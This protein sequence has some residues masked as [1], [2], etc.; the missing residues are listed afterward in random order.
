[1]N[2]PEP[3]T[4]QS[5]RIPVVTT[6]TIIVLVVG[7]FASACFYIL[8]EHYEQERIRRDLAR[9]IDIR[10]ALLRGNLQS[11]QDS[12]H[13]L[14]LLFENSEDI[15]WDE[16]Q[17]A[18]KDILSRYDSI[19]AIQWI[20]VVSR[21][22]RV[23]VETYA[24]QNIL[25]DYSFKDRLPD[26][27]T[28]SPSAD[29]DVYLPIL[30]NFPLEPNKAASGYNLLT[31]PTALAIERAR[32]TGKLSLTPKFNLIQL[33]S[34]VVM[35]APIQGKPSVRGDSTYGFVQIV[36]R[37]HDMLDNLWNTT[38]T[39]ILDFM[40]LDT[41]VPKTIPDV[42]FGRLANGMPI[43][44]ETD[45]ASFTNELTTTNSLVIG[46]RVWTAYY[47][48]SAG[49]L[50]QQDSGL[51][52]LTLAGCL[53]LAALGT[54]YVRT[55]GQR[56][57]HIATEV[58]QRTSELRHTKQLLETDIQQRRRTEAELQ[59]TS[60]QLS[61]ILGQIPGMVYRCSGSGTGRLLFVSNRSREITAYN[62][63]EIMR[64]GFDYLDLVHAD[65][66]DR[67]REVIRQAVSDHLPFEI[68]YRLHDRHGD[69]KWV[70]DRG[71]G[72]FDT[73][74]KLLFIEGLAIN[75]DDRRNAESEKLL[76]ERKLLEGQKLESLG[77]LAG[78]IAHDFNNLLTG[79]LG[80]ANLIKQSEI[81]ETCIPLVDR[82]ERSAL[83]AAELC[84]QMLA[85]SGRGRFS[86]QTIHL[87]QIAGDLLPLIE[88]SIS[89]QAR[90]HFDFETPSIPV[91][92]DPTQMRQIIMNLV[93]NAS[94]AIGDESGDIIL[95]TGRQRVDARYLQSCVL[96]PGLPSG[97]YAFFEV[98]DSGSG[99][100]AETLAKI[101]DPFFT[102]K[103]T[104][105]GLG[106]AAV[107]GIIRGHEG[108]LHVTSQ[109]GFGSTFRMLLPVAGQP[110]A[111][112]Q[113]SAP[114]PGASAPGTAS[115][116][117]EVSQPVNVSARILL[118][119]DDEQVRLVGEQILK[120]IGHRPTLAPDG[121]TAVQRFKASPLEFDLMLLDLTMPGMSGN[122]VLRI[123]RNISPGLRVLIM[124]GYSEQDAIRGFNDQPGIGFLQ[125]PFS[126]SVLRERIGKL[127]DAPVQ[128]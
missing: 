124:S 30:Y 97:D 117:P 79:I 100:N 112:L 108:A 38:P 9:Q 75:I 36:F 17:N 86:V 2:N 81:A 19:Q 104:G 3:D 65:D 48:P 43:S 1:M 73:D 84:Q 121:E 101:F 25:A 34:G 70:L 76:L 90:L 44:P 14:R 109:P 119:D 42:L 66:R 32:K 33:Q 107:L 63:D 68:E 95:K 23:E 115:P 125:K 128:S 72:V 20:P 103:F 126:M 6:G 31:A 69:T 55:L 64:E 26:S 96:S 4:G 80:H 15:S 74:N 102:T 71:I 92:V 60:R 57:R 37:L 106:L 89:K 88:A 40:V 10:H 16:F 59:E 29:N 49:W 67:Y 114:F 93:I 83:R 24:R 78:G 120:A 127:L 12:L 27:N 46:G 58:S 41:T 11:Y 5:P 62:P 39:P 7:L 82:I 35:V 116:I 13:S 47:R 113:S 52:A 122:E 22:Q 56:N 91:C 118:V 94:D 18:A 105:R 28:L 51:P 98:R 77:V 45:P 111:G 61:S 85:Y 8:V 123:V 21:E 110:F 54:A 87:D 53:L 99:M 50:A